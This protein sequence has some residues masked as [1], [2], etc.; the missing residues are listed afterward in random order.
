V[1]PH[2][3]RAISVQEVAACSKRQHPQ[4]AITQPDQPPHCVYQAASENHTSGITVTCAV[5]FPAKC[6]T[7]GTANQIRAFA[8]HQYYSINRKDFFH[9]QG[10]R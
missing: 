1:L 7:I 10:Y 6:C 2:H 4:P 3:F 9:G 8:L 5:P